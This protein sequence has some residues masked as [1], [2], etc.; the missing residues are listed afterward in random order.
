MS[1]VPT[2]FLIYV[3]PTP[4]CPI[5]PVIVPA[6]DCFEIL[7]GIPTDIQLLVVNNCDPTVADISDVIMSKT[8]PG[9]DMTDMAALPTNDSL[10]LVEF[11]FTSQSNQIGPQTFCVIAYTEE[12]LFH[13]QTVQQPQQRQ[14]RLQQ[15]AQLRPHRRLPQQQR[16]QQHQLVRQPQHQRVRQPQHQRVRQPQHQ[17]VRQP[18]AQQLQQLQARLLQ[19]PRRQ[20]QPQL[21]RRLLQRPRRQQQPQLQRRQQPQLQR[22]RQP[23][24]QRR[25]QPQ[26]QLRKSR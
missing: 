6:S 15:P 12:Q 17:R 26:Q 8:L 16:A 23:Q 4:T 13:L 24:Q 5:P 18:Q 25:R 14:R 2:Q 9:L 7:A 22:R 10:I 19:R 1:S 3:L 21:Q 11:N 20:Q